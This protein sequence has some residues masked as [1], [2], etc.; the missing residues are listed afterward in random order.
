MRKFIASDLVPMIE[1]ERARLA[2]C[3][4]SGGKGNLAVAHRERHAGHPYIEATFV[5]PSRFG[6]SGAEAGAKVVTVGVK[7][8]PARII[9]ERVRL[10]LAGSGGI[11][12]KLRKVNGVVSKNPSIQ[13]MWKPTRV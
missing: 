8:E 9:S 5:H 11:P 4:T 2:S 6:E 12:S 7:N 1:R 10:L 3:A 13:G